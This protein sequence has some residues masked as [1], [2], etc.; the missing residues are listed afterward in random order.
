MQGKITEIRGR[1]HKTVEEFQTKVRQRENLAWKRLG[2]A[3]DTRFETLLRGLSLLVRGL[4]VNDQLRRARALT[5]T[6]IL[7]TLPIGMIGLMV[8][9]KFD[10]WEKVRQSY[11]PMVTGEFPGLAKILDTVLDHIESANLKALGIMG[12]AFLLT[13]LYNMVMEVEVALNEVWQVP[14]KSGTF[15]RILRILLLFLVVPALML[16]AIFLEAI[17]KEAFGPVLEMV[18]IGH[19]TGWTSLVTVILASIAGAWVYKLLPNSAIPWRAALLGGAVNAVLFTLGTKLYFM[20]QVGVAKLSM[21]YS[22]LATLPFTLIWIQ[23]SWVI[24]LIGAEFSFAEAG[25]RRRS[26]LY[27]HRDL[28]PHHDEV[29]A[30]LILSLLARNAQVSVTTKEIATRLERPLAFVLD[31]LKRLSRAKLVRKEGKAWRL[32]DP[33]LKTASVGRLAPQLNIAGS[34]PRPDDLSG[35]DRLASE[36]LRGKRM[37]EEERDD[38]AWLAERWEEA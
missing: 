6:T 32:A 8:L 38:L 35:L 37:G 24:F 3:E 26:G 30:L 27:H 28:S 7:S 25:S 11:L 4:V 20:L 19:I 13:T 36:M 22:T 17:N 5:Y 31:L 2:G 10:A 23:W 21:V 34:G 16:A 1:V 33:D 18:G 14:E 29:T 12:I 9:E 15:L